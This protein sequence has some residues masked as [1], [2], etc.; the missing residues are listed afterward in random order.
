[1]ASS[2]Q[3]Q[4]YTPE[5]DKQYLK[6][7]IASFHHAFYEKLIPSYDNLDSQIDIYADQKVTRL[8]ESWPASEDDDPSTVYE[9]AHDAAIEYG[10]S[11]SHARY[12][13]IASSIIGT[14][15]LWEQQ[16]R[17]HVFKELSADA[18]IQL[19]IVPDRFSDLAVLLGDFGFTVVDFGF[20]SDLRLYNILVNVL[21][22][23]DGRSATQLRQIAPHYF[24]NPDMLSLTESPTQSYPL[25]NT[26]MDE[27]LQIGP[28]EPSQLVS[29]ILAFWDSLPERLYL[30][31]NIEEHK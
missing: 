21:K 23:G 12:L 7:Q 28:D 1:M 17:Q 15:H 30:T 31:V 26:L 19:G 6:Y 4:I 16:L 8:L 5:M 18:K 27:Q 20:Y 3:L 11:L 9:M 24:A 2:V 13:L 29:S 25:R 10:F 14:F 22:H